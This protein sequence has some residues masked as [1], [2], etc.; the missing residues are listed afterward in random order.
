VYEEVYGSENPF[1]A[2]EEEFLSP[3]ISDLFFELEKEDK[4]RKKELLESSN[5]RKKF[6]NEQ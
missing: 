2:E 3:M 6:L 4:I 1:I 5:D